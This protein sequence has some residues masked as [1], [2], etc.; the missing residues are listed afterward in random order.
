MKSPFVDLHRFT[1]VFST[2]VFWH[3]SER[4]SL[5]HSLT[6]HSR[7]TLITLRPCWGLQPLL[8]LWVTA[9]RLT[10]LPRCSSKS[11]SLI[12]HSAPPGV[13]RSCRANTV[14]TAQCQPVPSHP[15]WIMEMNLCRLKECQCNLFSTWY[16]CHQCNS[17][18]RLFFFSSPPVFKPVLPRHDQ[19]CTSVTGRYLKWSWYP[20]YDCKHLH[21]IL[22]GTLLNRTRVFVL[23]YC[24]NAFNSESCKLTALPRFTFPWPPSWNATLCIWEVFPWTEVKYFSARSKHVVVTFFILCVEIP[25]MSFKGFLLQMFQHR[26]PFW[27]D[28]LAHIAC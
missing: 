5:S 4:V 26:D 19:F 21:H 22:H 8:F 3:R 10:E 7:S 2:A 27:C 6:S 18:L 28:I 25:T 1:L 23:Y 11:Q 20:Q 12:T 24:Y 14:S 9:W 15:P 13:I 16:S 17:C